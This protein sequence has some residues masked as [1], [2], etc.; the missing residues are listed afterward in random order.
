MYIIFT[1][2]YALFYTSFQAYKPNLLTLG[3]A[4]TVVD[5]CFSSNYDDFTGVESL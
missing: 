5:F 1:F 3:H 2:C 4:T